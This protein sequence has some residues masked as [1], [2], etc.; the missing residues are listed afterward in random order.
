[1]HEPKA[2]SLSVS[3]PGCS[4]CEIRMLS[5]LLLAERHSVTSSVRTKQDREAFFRKVLVRMRSMSV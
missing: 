2:L 1:M 4:V 5:M 3:V